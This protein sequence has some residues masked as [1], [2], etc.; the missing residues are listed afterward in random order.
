MRQSRFV[1]AVVLTSLCHVS[2]GGGV[3]ASL[4]SEN[5]SFCQAAWQPLTGP[6]PF[7]VTSGLVYN[8]GTLYYSSFNAQAILAVPAAGTSPTVLAPVAS[9]ELWMEGDHLLFSGGSEGSQIYTLPLAGGTPQLLLD[10]AAGRSGVGAATAHAFTAMDFYWIEQDNVSSGVGSSTVWHQDRSGGA[11][12][13]IGTTSFTDP[14][15]FD[16]PGTAIA[17]AGDS[18]VVGSAF[19]QAATVP[20]GGGAATPLA[21]PA[22]SADLNVQ[23]SLA[24]IDALGVYWSVPGPGDQPGTLMVSPAD[25]G[26]A[27]P[28]S[29]S[30]PLGGLVQ[31]I[32]PAPDGGWVAASLQIFSDGIDRMTIWLVDAQ[33]HAKLL[34]CSPGPASESWVEKGVAVTSDAVYVPVENLSAGTWQIDRIAR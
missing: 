8:A 34:A 27:K 23:S 15:G 24:G 32:W 26:P 30:T 6:Q 5:P 31:R 14:N 18:V 17:L 28:F 12:T 29:A 4:R 2:C 13:Q 1:E 16:F 33:A 3:G 9:L 11:P 25:G 22:T 21:T 10:G 7:D 20:V 19:G